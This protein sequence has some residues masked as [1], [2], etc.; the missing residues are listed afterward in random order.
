MAEKAELIARLQVGLA[1][2]GE[3]SL[4]HEVI[5]AKGQRGEPEELS[6]I[7]RQAFDEHVRGVD[8]SKKVI[9]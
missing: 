9:G 2:S 4:C 1:A 3:C 7:L 6:G 5:V 8:L